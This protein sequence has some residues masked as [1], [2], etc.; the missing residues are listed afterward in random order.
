VLKIISFD[1]ARVGLQNF[2]LIYLF[3]SRHEVQSKCLRVG[4]ES[5]Y[6][7]LMQEWNRSQRF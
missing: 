2:F 5:D 6:V 1:L 7:Q 4:L 3:V